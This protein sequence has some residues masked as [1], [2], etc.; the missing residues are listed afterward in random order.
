MTCPNCFTPLPDDTPGLRICGQCLRS[1]VVSED[2]VRLANGA[3]TTVLSPQELGVLRAQR[4]AAR[5]IRTI[6]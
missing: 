2:T 3:D 4:K 5:N 1:L 6:H